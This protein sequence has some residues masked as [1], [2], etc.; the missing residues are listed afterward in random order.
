MSHPIH[1]RL[2]LLQVS[3]AGVLWGTGGLAVQVV[4]EHSTMSV[5]T[6]SAWRMALAA[7]VLLAAVLVLRQSR[8]VARLLRERPLPAIA[9]TASARDED[10]RRALAAGFNHYLRK[11][12]DP[13]E[14]VAALKR[15][16]ADDST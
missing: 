1:S 15:C 13:A 4:R 5:L 16:V 7:V 10:R 2:G 12:V 9:L 11:P 3:L 6:I 8:D 14:L